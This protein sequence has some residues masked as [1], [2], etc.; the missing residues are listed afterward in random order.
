[1]KKTVTAVAIVL[2]A[3]GCGD[4]AST[5]EDA[6]GAT[7]ATSMVQMNLTLPEGVDAFDYSITGGPAEISRGGS[8]QPMGDEVLKFHVGHLPAGRGYTLIIRATTL[9]GQACAGA[10]AFGINLGSETTLT[11]TLICDSGASH[12]LGSITLF[13]DHVVADDVEC[14][15]VSGVSV[16]PLEVLVGA[17]LTLE[18]FTFPEEIENAAYR[19]RGAGNDFSDTRTLSTRYTCAIPGEHNLRLSVTKDRCPLNFQEV[20][21]TCTRIDR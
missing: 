7:G 17:N 8:I 11:M 15:V 10:A 16:L 20:A 4:G 18:G 9:D 14:P 5:T 21:V 1:M 19:W 2:A 13:I 3:G 6:I 12:E